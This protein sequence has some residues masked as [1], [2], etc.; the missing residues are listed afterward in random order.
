MEPNEGPKPVG[1]GEKA[2]NW[3]GDASFGV[4]H[5][6]AKYHVPAMAAAGGWFLREVPDDVMQ[7]NT[8][9]AIVKGLYA[10]SATWEA[11]KSA[12]RQPQAAPGSNN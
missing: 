7:G 2:L 6:L 10:V 5:L 9:A 11:F 3:L 8:G 1:K 12:G 4:L